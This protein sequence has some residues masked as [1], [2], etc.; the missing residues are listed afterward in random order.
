MPDKK[1]LAYVGVSDRC[2]QGADGTAVPRA[3]TRFRRVLGTLPDEM[4]LRTSASEDFSDTTL[5]A[6]SA[7]KRTIST[8]QPP[9]RCTELL[10]FY[11]TC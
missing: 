10:P 4:T 2:A 11:Q 5:T 1:P 8:I 6:I 7:D 3:E 9:A